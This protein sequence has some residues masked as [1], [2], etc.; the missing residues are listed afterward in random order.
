MRHVPNFLGLGRCVTNSKELYTPHPSC[1]HS[2]ERQDHEYISSDLFT[3][4][5]PILRTWA[6]TRGRLL[7]EIL[8]QPE[9]MWLQF[10][11]RLDKLDPFCRIAGHTSEEVR[12]IL[13]AL[14]TVYR[15]PFPQLN[16]RLWSDSIYPW[17]TLYRLYYQRSQAPGVAQCRERGTLHPIPS[18][19]DLP[20]ILVLS[21]QRRRLTR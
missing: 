16:L 17:L 12:E 4:H 19:C 18:T 7:K 8:D 14:E 3:V 5:G 13:A 2:Q 15:G 6:L 1:R 21:D 9:T 11:R 10:R 20:R